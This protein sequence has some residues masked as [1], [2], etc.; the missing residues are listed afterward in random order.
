V[1]TIKVKGQDVKVG[2]DIWFLGTPHRVTRITPYV[3]PV[4]TRN[5]EWRTAHSDGPD[6]MYKAAWGIT[7]EFDHGWA[8][9]YEVTYTEGD[10]RAEQYS[11][12]DYL[13]AFGS[14][15]SV[16]MFDA[17]QAQGMPG[18]WRKW[19]AERGEPAPDYGPGY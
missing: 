16:E 5:E 4:C 18:L 15:R 11:A 13:S 10:P 9:G 19:L 3:H 17:Y 1:S 7:L 8:A 2:D 14:G 6:G 12:C